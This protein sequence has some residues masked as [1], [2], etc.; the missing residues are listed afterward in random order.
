MKEDD[1]TLY[2]VEVKVKTDKAYLI[3]YEDEEYT[4]FPALKSEKTKT[5]KLVRQ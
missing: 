4:G 1:V 2:A 3:I 5:L